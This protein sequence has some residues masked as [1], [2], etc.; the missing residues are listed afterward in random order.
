MQ[1]EFG[2]RTAVRAVDDVD[3]IH[4]PV[5]VGRDIGARPALVENEPHFLGAVDRHDRHEHVAA[6]CQPVKRGDGLAPVRELERDDVTRK[7]PGRGERA[8]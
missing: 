4:V 3:V 7:N 6:H 8:R 5:P 1:V 2:Q